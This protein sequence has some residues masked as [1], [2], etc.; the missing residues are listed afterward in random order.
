M[1]TRW[2]PLYQKGNPQLRIFLPNFW[3]KLIEPKHKQ[4]KN[5]VQFECSMEMT[6]FDVINYLEKIYNVKPVDVRTRI[7]LGKCKKLHGRYYVIKEDDVKLAYVILDK[8]ESFTFPD[9]FPQKENKTESALDEVKQ[10]FKLYL[11]D[12]KEPSEPGWFRI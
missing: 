8:K 1:S 12:C 6:K 7:A 11:K 10:D 2:Y 9:L 4:P 5:V 3:L